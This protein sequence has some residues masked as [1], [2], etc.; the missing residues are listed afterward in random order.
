MK[1]RKAKPSKING[2]TVAPLSVTRGAI[3]EVDVIIDNKDR[4]LDNWLAL[5]RPTFPF[6]IRKIGMCRTFLTVVISI[7][8]V[9][10][11]TTA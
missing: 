9:F 7:M 2:A 8:V 3:K 10:T 5:V 4:D 1:A 6:P 11:T